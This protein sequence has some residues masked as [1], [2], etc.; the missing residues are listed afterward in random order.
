V[1]VDTVTWTEVNQA[2]LQDDPLGDPEVK[3]WHSALAD[4]TKGFKIVPQS[5]LCVSRNDEYI[6]PARPVGLTKW[7]LHINASDLGFAIVANVAVTAAIDK[8][9]R[10]AGVGETAIVRSVNG[11]TDLQG[12]LKL[13]LAADVG[14]IRVTVGG[15][16]KVIDTTDLGGTGLFYAALPQ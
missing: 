10:A 13:T 4:E 9:S 16:S 8:P 2:I 11:V 6:Y 15:A 1:T 5:A 14:K 12:Y 7:E 3:Y